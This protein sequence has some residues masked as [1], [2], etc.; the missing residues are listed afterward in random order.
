LKDGGFFLEANRKT[1]TR[2]RKVQKVWA[3]KLAHLA[4]GKVLDGGEQKDNS[5]NKGEG[6]QKNGTGTL[7]LVEG[8]FLI[9]AHRKTTRIKVRR[10]L[11][12]V[13]TRASSPC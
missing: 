11:R 12:R 9:E 10:D 1:R 3:S 8:G 6:G 7:T 13:G 4:R 2:V 5:Q